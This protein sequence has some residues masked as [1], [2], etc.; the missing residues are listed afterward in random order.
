MEN[1][2]QPKSEAI[3]ATLNKQNKIDADL[4]R[5]VATR[6]E[7]RTLETMTDEQVNEVASVFGDLLRSWGCA[8][9]MTTPQDVI[10]EAEQ[11]ECDEDS[12]VV[13]TSVEAKKV[14]KYLDQ[15]NYLNETHGEIYTDL[16]NEAI[17]RKKGGA[18]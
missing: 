4:L 17:A 5:D 18:K 1:T 2:N 7:A 14:C 9:F 8:V 13:L 3:R 15:N 16:I 10:D 6:L 12:P 11:A